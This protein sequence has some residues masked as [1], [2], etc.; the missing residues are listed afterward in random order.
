MNVT[1][2]KWDKKSK[3]YNKFSGNLNDFQKKFFKVLDEFG[4][5]FKG[6][7]MIDI[8]CGTGAYTLYLA[9]L[10][11]NI[12]GI[13]SSIK[14]LEE[15]EKSAKEFNITN[16]KTKN[17]SF[18]EF[19]SS[20][21]FDIAFLTMSPALQTKEH[22]QKFIDL[23]ELKIY[24]NWYK[25]RHSTLLEPFFKKYGK[26]S[27]TNRTSMLKSYLEISKIPYKSE[28]LTEMRIQNRSYEEAVEN[29]LWHLD[30]N[31]LNFNEDEVKDEI[32]AMLEGG[33]I[34]DT[35]NSKMQLLV[36]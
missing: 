32:K 12:L 2:N 26:N 5:D 13:D 24:L 36:F 9:R 29:V 10:C 25:P 15:L 6:K 18:D 30:I 14:M 19:E 33:F 8:G 34:K 11:K 28:I 27:L 20:D 16:V 31:N 7:T 1:N 4:V 3:T 22:F 23:G 35:I 17:F 21:K